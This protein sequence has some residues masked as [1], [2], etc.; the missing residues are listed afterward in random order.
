MGAYNRT[1]GE[2]CCGSNTLIKDILRKKW[3]FSGHFVSDCWAIRDFHQNHKVTANPRE[4]VLMAL[5]AGCDLNCGCTYEHVMAAYAEGLVDEKLIT[6][7]A[8]RLFTTRYLLGLFEGSEYDQI[9]YEVIECKDHIDF[10]VSCAAKSAVLLKNDGVLPLSKEKITSI[11][12]VGP[13]ANSRQALIGNYHGTSSRYIT[14]L[15]GIQDYLSDTG[16]AVHYSE[17]CHLYKDKVEDLGKPG[18]RLAEAR[19][20]ANHSDVVIVCLGLDETLEGEEPDTGNSY[21]SGDKRDLKFPGMQEQLLKTIVECGKPTIVVVLSGS[22]LDLAYADSNANAILQAWY[23]GARGGKAIA[24]LLFGKLSPSG[25]L[26]VTFYKDTNTMPSFTDYSMKNRTYRFM[27]ESA[28]YPFGFGLTYSE[29]RVKTL[30]LVSKAAAGADIE[31]AVT[32]EN[33]GFV[34]TEDVIEVYVKDLESNLAVRNYSLCG[35]KRVSLAPGQRLTQSITLAKS[36]FEVVDEKG[37]RRLD[38]TAFRLY[39][40]L[41]QPDERSMELT[42]SNA[43]AL[44]LALEKV[45]C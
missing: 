30:E 41:C 44:D 15:E 18:D 43:I 9:G 6:Q 40:G 3:G 16:I 39:A 45:D 5:Q 24:D 42:R 19:S 38:S 7:A 29:V 35:F 36:C 8:V 4:S 23:P 27:E 21:I 37:E 34:A 26:P 32:V 10:A 31:I 25:K 14:V 1:N 17:G 12:V 33:E 28:L 22:S 20:V 2:P 11:G 13:N